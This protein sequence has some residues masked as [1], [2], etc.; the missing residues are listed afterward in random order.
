[1][2]T[3]LT[4]CNRAAVGDSKNEVKRGTPLGKN[5]GTI[6]RMLKELALKKI[7]LQSHLC[8]IP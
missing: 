4:T 8:P 7:N 2:E 6:A 5:T 3:N 1:V